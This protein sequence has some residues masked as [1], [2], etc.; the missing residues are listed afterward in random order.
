MGSI[1]IQIVKLVADNGYNWSSVNMLLMFFPPRYKSYIIHILYVEI[2]SFYPS[3]IIIHM[4]RFSTSNTKKCKL[5]TSTKHTPHFMRKCWHASYICWNWL[6]CNEYLKLFV[7]KWIHRANLRQKIS[8]HTKEVE[9]QKSSDKC[10]G[11][12]K[13]LQ[14]QQ[15]DKLKQLWI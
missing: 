14:D 11:K 12:Q 13:T 1:H 15:K 9:T 7:M 2:R 4:C 8:F 10:R 3:K 5:R 6:C